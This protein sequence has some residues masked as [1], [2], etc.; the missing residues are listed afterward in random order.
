MM[1]F[2]QTA[3]IHKDP[4]L[5]SEH[6]TKLPVER[7]WLHWTIFEQSSDK[8]SQKLPHC[9]R[10]VW[11]RKRRARRL[12]S[13]FDRNGELELEMTAISRWGLFSFSI[14]APRAS[15]LRATSFSKA[16]SEMGGN[17]ASV[18]LHFVVKRSLRER[19]AQRVQ[20]E[21]NF[22][23]GRGRISDCKQVAPICRRAIKVQ[24]FS[25]KASFEQ[26]RCH[27]STI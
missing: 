15:Q 9:S 19:I 17:C 18:L 14:Y 20:K 22:E 1:R 13:K 16:I 5:E 24:K 23:S 6:A 21:A 26:R 10:L 4:Q 3:L 8:N 2:L 25:N 12:C 11:R 7:N 27:P